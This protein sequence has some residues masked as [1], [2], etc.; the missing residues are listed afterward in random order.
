MLSFNG[1]SSCYTALQRHTHSSIRGHFSFRLISLLL[2]FRW[3]LK[4]KCV[5]V[6][7]SAFGARAKNGALWQVSFALLRHIGRISDFSPLTYELNHII[8]LVLSH[9]HFPHT[10]THSAPVLPHMAQRYNNRNHTGE[11]R[12]C[13]W[14]SSTPP[15][16]PFTCAD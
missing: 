7:V 2:L 6:C 9:S 11:L 13:F 4:L 15:I 5:C 16:L 12:S 1:L 3:N 8:A 14:G 10:C